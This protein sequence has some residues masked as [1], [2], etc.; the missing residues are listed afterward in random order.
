MKEQAKQY[1][2]IGSKWIRSAGSKLAK[3]AKE[4]MDEL[5][6]AR[7]AM[8]RSVGDEHELPAHYYE[9]AATL[10]ELSPDQRATV[11]NTLPE[12]DRLH[13]QRILDDAIIS[14]SQRRV[15][16]L[17][18]SS[19]SGDITQEGAS[20]RGPA[21]RY[22]HHD[23]KADDVN[24]SSRG[25]PSQPDSTPSGGSGGRRRPAA[26]LQR[27]SAPQADPGAHPAAQHRRSGSD[28]AAAAARRAAA[29]RFRT[30]REAELAFNVEIA[31]GAASPVKRRPLPPPYEAAA[32][33]Q[34]EV[35]SRRDAR[36]P[37]VQAAPRPVST[38]EAQVN[39]PGL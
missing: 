28:P 14:G 18:H 13:V 1:I 16:T 17:G 11:L 36:P 38:P 12:D 19:G 4:K 3:V 25:S 15:Q 34:P 7:K 8:V 5:E 39:S 26:V 24:S 31:G 10:S 29:E 23:P 2:G 32:R 35:E 27:E 37:P 20:S 33:R 21:P 30:D 6:V 9:W 22:P